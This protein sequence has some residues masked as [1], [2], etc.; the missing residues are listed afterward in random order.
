MGSLLGFDSYILSMNSIL[1]TVKRGVWDILLPVF[2]STNSKNPNRSS[3]L[4]S[5]LT[6]F[7]SRF[8]IFA[9]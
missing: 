3:I 7:K 2:F 1:S 4:R 9:N 5:C 8:K 6:D